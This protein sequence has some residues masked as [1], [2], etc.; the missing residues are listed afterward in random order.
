[1]IVDY[2]SRTAPTSTLRAIHKHAFVPLLLDS[3][4]CD[5]SADVDFSALERVAQRMGVASTGVVSQREFLEHNGI[6]VLL[7]KSLRA[8]RTDQECAALVDGFDRV[9][10]RMG[11]AYHVMALSSSFAALT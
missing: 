5:L 2:G 1:M 4:N 11:T 3:G 9:V 7:L 10:N 8:A 6:D